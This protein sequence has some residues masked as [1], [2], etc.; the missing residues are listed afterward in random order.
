MADV[1]TEILV[2]QLPHENQD[3]DQKLKGGKKNVVEEF[4]FAKL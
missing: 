2:F 4:S 1:R 3:P